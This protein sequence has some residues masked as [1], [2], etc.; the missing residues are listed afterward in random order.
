MAG[1]ARRVDRR[2]C[3]AGRRTEASPMQ[4]LPSTHARIRE[5]ACTRNRPLTHEFWQHSPHPGFLCFHALTNRP[6]CRLFVL[7]TLQQWGGCI[8]GSGGLAGGADGRGSPGRREG[9]ATARTRAVSRCVLRR[10]EPADDPWRRRRHDCSSSS[11][12]AP[13]SPDRAFRF[14]PARAE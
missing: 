6:I 11:G 14:S 12:C 9:G 5:A 13:S 7:I 10:D 2:L 8:G 1:P 4:C 3:F